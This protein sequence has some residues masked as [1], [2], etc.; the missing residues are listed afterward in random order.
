MNCDEP[1]PHCPGA[2]NPEGMAFRGAQSM[3]GVAGI[4]AAG[5]DLPQTGSARLQ[6]VNNQKV[7][8]GQPIAGKASP[9]DPMNARIPFSRFG[10]PQR[11]HERS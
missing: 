9:G 2:V 8:N 3:V 4:R 7:I 10:E 1:N 11:C 5:K 6:P